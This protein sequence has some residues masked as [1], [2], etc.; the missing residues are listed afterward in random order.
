MQRASMR[1]LLTGGAGYI[2]SVLV[3]HLVGR[4]HE[5]LVYDNLSQGHR[6]ALPADVALV[7]GDI[8]DEHQLR[9]TCTAFRP[10]AVCHLA[11]RTSV[12]ESM[13][14]PDLY[15]ESNTLG[16]FRVFQTAILAGARTLVLSSTAAV[17]GSPV[18]LPI[19][20]SHPLQPINPYGWS[21]LLAERCLEA[22][23]SIHQVQWCAFRYFNA[24]G[25]SRDPDR[26]YLGEDHTPE[27]HLIPRLI[28]AARM[29]QPV[30]LYGDQH[31]TPDGSCVRDF[32]HVDDLAEAHI[33]GLERPDLCHGQ[34]WNLGSGKGW[35]VREVIAAC[36]EVHGS[37]LEV[38]CLPARAGDPP[39]LVASLEKT[40]THLG[41]KPTSSSL[42]TIIRSAYEWHAGH[43][44]GYRRR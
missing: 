35:S 43:P 26:G 39:L 32:I 4:G 7:V 24:C 23:A 30:H 37:R 2:G 25:A 6:E 27:T 10:E 8:L 15:L 33:L 41:W 21:K 29:G 19:V 44:E 36:E 40:T 31:A 3:R 18:S 20:E 22:L 1:I 34:A 38:A 16:A 42:S 14:H 13:Q 28:E 5:C 12:G 11:A 17:Y 9:Q